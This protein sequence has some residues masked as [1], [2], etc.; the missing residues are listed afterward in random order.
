MNELFLPI[1]LKPLEPSTFK[2]YIPNIYREHFT[3]LLETHSG[4]DHDKYSF[5]L[6]DYY[7][8]TW[9]LHVF[10]SRGIS[11]YNNWYPIKNFCAIKIAEL[12]DLLVNFYIEKNTALLSLKDIKKIKEIK[13]SAFGKNF[14]ENKSGVI[15]ENSRFLQEKQISN[16]A[17]WNKSD[18]AIRN[19]FSVLKDTVIEDDKYFIL[20]LINQLNSNL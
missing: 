13:F 7:T 19:K 12:L 5:Y 18:I 2:Y 4:K 3:L 16:F 1:D 10:H 9:I 20:H 17:P 8:S 6:A 11:I 14:E 15:N